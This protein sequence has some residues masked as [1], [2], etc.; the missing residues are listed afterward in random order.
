[1]E[2]IKRI[3]Y[4]DL[5]EEYE[6][7][8]PDNFHQSLNKEQGIETFNTYEDYERSVVEKSN[9]NHEMFMIAESLCNSERFKAYITDD[10]KSELDKNLELYNIKFDSK[11]DRNNIYHYMI[12]IDELSETKNMGFYD[13]IEYAK[14]LMK[15]DK[16]NG[17]KIL[18]STPILK[19]GIVDVNLND[20][21]VKYNGKYLEYYNPSGISV[22]A[23]LIEYRKDEN[24]NLKEYAIEAS[25]MDYYIMET[26]NYYNKI[27]QRTYNDY[28][29]KF[30]NQILNNMKSITLVNANYDNGWA[31]FCAKNNRTNSYI[32]ID[33][34]DVM[35][36]PDYMLSTYTHE[37]GHA[38]AAASSSNNNF[39]IN[40]LLNRSD[41]DNKSEW[42]NVYNQIIQN[43]S[44]KTFLKEYAH[45]SPVEC[46]AECVAEFYA[47]SSDD[48]IYN[49]NDLKAID[50]EI[51]GQEMTLYDYMDNLLN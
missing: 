44:N 50:I 8:V 34:N 25:E 21:E 17:Y 23:P 30:R 33:M 15:Y 36:S 3:E 12:H 43:D 37:L 45:S 27:M 31:A 29:D 1:M 7:D 32:T 38:Y 35:K 10:Y 22:K 2:N 14:Y 28:S 13:K 46:F 5:Y 9:K 47:N 19:S 49:P 16:E 40:N 6:K 42:K 41:I 39:F 18:F 20:E 11:E 48:T 51:N 4:H 24:G 26:N